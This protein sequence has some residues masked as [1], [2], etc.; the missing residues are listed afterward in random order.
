[1]T[2]FDIGNA[3]V[4]LYQA[5]EK[6][7]AASVPCTLEGRLVL[8]SSGY[9]LLEVPNDLGNGAFKALNEAGKEQPISESRGGYNA[10]ITVLRPDEV[11][12]AGDAVN[13]YRGKTFKF[14][15]GSVRVID[16]PAGWKEVSK[17][18]VLS[19]RSPELIKMRNALDLGPPKY[20]F[21][22]TFAIRKRNALRDTRGLSSF[23]KLAANTSIRKSDV[24][25]KGLFATKAFKIGEP[26]ISRFMTK[27]PGKDNLVRWEQSDEAR[28]TNHSD[29]PNILVVKDGD[30]LRLEAARD[31][32]PNE[33]LRA[34]YGKT[35]SNI[36]PGFYYTY[37]GK[38]Y[39]GPVSPALEKEAV[40]K[41][42]LIT[43][44][45]V[46]ARK[47]TETP[48]SEAQAAAG[49]YKKGKVVM[50]GMTISIENPK[51]S[52]RSGTDASGKKWSTV[53]KTDYGYVLGTVGRDKDHVDVF[54]GDSPEVELVYVVNQV[55]P[56]S[57]RF[58]EH[59]VM[60]GYLSEDDA[61][62]AYLANYEKDWQGLGSIVAMTMS[63]FKEWLDKGDQRK[64]AA[65]GSVYLNALK[66]TPLTWDKQ[67]DA[68]GNL[69]THLRRVRER[70]DT[71]INEAA[72]YDRL[73]NAMDPNRANQQFINYLQGTK[74]PLVDHPLDRFL[75]G[76]SLS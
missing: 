53:M 16:N 43:Q 61:K 24:H 30:Y 65:T 19:V 51:G 56:Q 27:F 70:G 10:H 29:D 34:D 49:N 75:Q 32:A 66:T 14:N 5:A 20:P 48:K 60:M 62:S 54:I 2:D 35:T 69:M 1:M 33:E 42:Q 50:H 4:H 45:L 36:G 39:G 9:M 67:Q 25:G 28:Y 38:P 64:K 55:D 8:S 41:N 44:Q 31:I 46:Q 23:E 68:A 21:H 63:D 74:P 47:D 59:K 57:K 12:K 17:C 11:A 18:W 7:A 71:A 26:I 52:T 72:T 37:Q 13:A 76:E 6:Q 22:I 58:D 73:Q 15:L 3:I 40:N